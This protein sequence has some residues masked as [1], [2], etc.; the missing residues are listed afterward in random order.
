M[1]FLINVFRTLVSK[2]PFL[3]EKKKHFDLGNFSLNFKNCSPI[4]QNCVT[5]ANDN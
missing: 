3:F 1:D 2:I 4:P 5:I